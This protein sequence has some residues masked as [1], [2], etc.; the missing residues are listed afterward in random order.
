MLPPLLPLLSC[1]LKIVAM[2]A[3]AANFVAYL[4]GT[5]NF[6][7]AL[8][9][10]LINQGLDSFAAFADLTDDDI[11]QICSVIRK[12]GGTIPNPAY[13]AQQHQQANSAAVPA[14][15]A[16]HWHP[17]TITNLGIPVPLPKEKILRQICYLPN[18]FVRIQRT[19]DQKSC[20]IARLLSL[21]RYKTRVEDEKNDDVK[22]L[23]KLTNVS[24]IRQVLENIKNYLRVKRGVTGGFLSYVVRDVVELGNID[25]G[26]GEP[27]IDAEMVRHAPHDIDAFHVHSATVWNVICHVT[28]DGPGWT[29]VSA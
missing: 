4:T 22:L 24:N 20:T 14:I 7:R 12:P 29:W 1:C 6:A 28:H 25:P 5:H 8:A 19:F 9:D 15:P 13:T 18:H 23:D 16:P 27:T 17:Q 21:W 10:E 11:K 2:A 3:A 26:F